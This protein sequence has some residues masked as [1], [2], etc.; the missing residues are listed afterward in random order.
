MEVI[1]NNIKK[2]APKLLFQ[3]GEKIRKIRMILD[4]ENSPCKSD[5]FE[6]SCFL[7]PR[8]LFI[9]NVNIL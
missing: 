7:G 8:Q 2:C 3:V 4:M 1:K 5:M 6:I 9:P